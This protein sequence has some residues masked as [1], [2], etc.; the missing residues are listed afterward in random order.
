[1][2]VRCT[3]R[4]CYNIR[5]VGLVQHPLGLIPNACKRYNL[6]QHGC[7]KMVTVCKMRLCRKFWSIS[8]EL[9]YRTVRKRFVGTLYFVEYCPDSYHSRER[10]PVAPVKNLVG[11][12]LGNFRPWFVHRFADS[13]AR[14]AV[15]CLSSHAGG[16]T[17]HSLYLM[18]CNMA[19]PTRVRVH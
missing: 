1:M 14:L 12:V 15:R 16:F 2:A 17:A 10:V 5:R 7:G 13:V 8:C 3:E 4:C 6:V 9:R 11:R 18:M 19:R